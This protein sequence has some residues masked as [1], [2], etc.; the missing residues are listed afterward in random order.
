MPRAAAA[1]AVA[2]ALAGCAARQD[3]LLAQARA[4]FKTAAETCHEM[5]TTHLEKVKCKQ[6]AYHRTSYAYDRSGTRD[7]M[8]LLFAQSAVLAAKVDRHELTEEEA[9]LQLTQMKADLVEQARE[10][11][12]Q[13]QQQLATAAVAMSLMRSSQPYYPSPTPW[14]GSMANRP[15]THCNSNQLGWTVYTNCY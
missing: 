6:A 13:E 3:P 15:L 9:N 10:R 11:Q 5:D 2:S 1:I 12:Q 8:E 7:A 4:D 14:A